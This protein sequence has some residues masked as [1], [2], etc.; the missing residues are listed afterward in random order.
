VSVVSLKASAPS[1]PAHTPATAGHH[2]PSPA[3][4]SPAGAAGTAQLSAR[5]TGCRSIPLRIT[6]APAHQLG[7]LPDPEVEGLTARHANLHVRAGSWVDVAAG[8]RMFQAKLWR[9]CIYATRQSIC[10]L[11]CCF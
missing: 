10:D 3:P 5:S 8:K 6:P 2:A 4:R 9:R 1:L 7:A 11:A